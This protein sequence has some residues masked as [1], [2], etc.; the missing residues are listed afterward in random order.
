M[1]HALGQARRL[2]H[3]NGELINVND[4]PVPHRIEVHTP[5]TV[6]KVGWLQDRENFADTLSAFNALAQVV[7][8]GDFRLEDE[9]DFDFNI[10]VDDLPE[11]QTW[12]AEWWSTAILPDNVIQRIEELYR[13]ASQPAR[14]VLG[15]R[16][17]MIKL[18]AA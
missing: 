3:L 15:L 7:A 1:V 2:L 16:V 8:D 5:E 4:L 11:L 17:R 6:Y 13:E 10:Y 12:L 9:R 18:R 14:I